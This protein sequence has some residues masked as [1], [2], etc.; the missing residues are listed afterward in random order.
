MC[1]F[2][3]CVSLILL[4]PDTYNFPVCATAALFPFSLAYFITCSLCQN[5]YLIFHPLYS[6]SW[7]LNSVSS[8]YWYQSSLMDT[9]ANILP[10]QQSFF[11]NW[12]ISLC[13][14]FQ[15]SIL[16]LFVFPFTYFSKIFWHCNFFVI[17]LPRCHC[18]GFDND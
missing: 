11:F 3:C 13:P 2:F 7:G 18:Y 5:V 15:V 6:Y 14:V 1:I 8:I 16:P 4:S 12:H 17:F 10:L 9:H